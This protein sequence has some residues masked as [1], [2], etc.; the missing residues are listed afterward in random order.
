MPRRAADPK[1]SDPGLLILGSLADGPKHGLAIISDLKETSGQVIG[2]GT[3][4]GVIARLESRGLVERLEAED[5]RRRPYRLT[6]RGAEVLAEQV[7]SME[8]FAHQSNSR[9]RSSRRSCRGESCESPRAGDDRRLPEA[10]SRPVREEMTAAAEQ[11][12]SWR[13]GLD[14][15]RGAVGAWL[16]PAVG[17]ESDRRHDRIVG[18]VA[19]AFFAWCALTCASGMFSKAVDDQRAPGLRSWGWT[20]YSVGRG[21]FEITA[22]VI[23]VFGLAYWLEVVVPAARAHSRAVLVP[24]LAPIPIVAT[25]L[26]VTGLVSL[27]ANHYLATG[28]GGPGVI[29]F[30]VFA[31]YVLITVVS[32]AACSGC[33]VRALDRADIDL[34]KLRP[35]VV[36]SA[37]AAP[38]FVAQTVAA[39]VAL[40]RV[41]EIGGI[42]ERGVVL[43]VPPVVIMACA[44]AAVIFSGSTGIRA[45]RTRDDDAQPSLPGTA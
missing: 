5:A 22:V 38:A 41:L 33:A 45:L 9:L 17:T 43:A 10:V 44:S 32:V 18:S 42:G 40:T 36:L 28:P 20:G 30:V 34:R 3:L 11:H 26:G 15:A 37:L 27:Y 2:P 19:V 4:Y 39:A 29:G 31:A 23:A 12:F 25:W 35:A 6:S 14:L 16:S 1:W 8:A 21:I 13:V 7:T 24:A